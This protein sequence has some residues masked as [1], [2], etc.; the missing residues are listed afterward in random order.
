MTF[1]EGRASAVFSPEEYVQSQRAESAFRLLSAT[2]DVQLLPDPRR[3]IYTYT[4]CLETVGGECADRWRHQIP[5]YAGDV[6]G[7]AAHDDHGGLE[8]VRPDDDAEGALEVRFRR[9]VRRGERYSFRYSYETRITSVVAPGPLSLT[10]TYGDWLTANMACSRFEV[11][12]HVPAGAGGLVTVPAPSHEQQAVVTY[13]RAGL[14]PLET[15]GFLVAY[16]QWNLGWK[17]WQW[18]GSAVAFA[19]VAELV[20]SLLTRF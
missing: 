7:V 3:A 20:H 17:F 2:V 9:P 5:M 1:G 14:R 6:T 16:R 11:R 18:V 8:F 10:V 12:V 15:V 4:L 13:R 19:L